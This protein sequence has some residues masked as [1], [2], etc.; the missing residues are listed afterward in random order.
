MSSTPSPAGQT[1]VS[2]PG[3]VLLTGGYLV[4]EAPNPG[5][6]AA[7]S[8][9]FYTTILPCT[10]PSPGGEGYHLVVHSPQFHE[11]R[12]YTVSVSPSSVHVSRLSGGANGYVEMAL[13]HAFAYASSRG[14][15]TPPPP[16]AMADTLVLVADNGF[17][18]QMDALE[19]RGL[20]QSAEGLA[21]LP[22]FLALDTSREL[23]KTGLGSSAALITSLVGA[24][25]VHYAGLDLAGGNTALETV[26]FVA[27]AAH[28]AA[29]GKIGSGF[30]VSSAT[31]GSQRYTRFSPEVLNALAADL[32][33]ASPTEAFDPSPLK[34]HGPEAM[35]S[36]VDPWHLP[37]GM[38]LILA[39]TAVGSKTPGMVR[40]ILKWKADGGDDAAAIWN[41]L[42][43]ANAAVEASLRIVGSHAREF[44]AASAAAIATLASHPLGS[45]ED[46]A[47]GLNDPRA[48]EW[49]AH[50]LRLR[51]EFETVRSLLRAMSTAAGVP[52]EPPEQTALL[53]ATLELPGVVFA[54]VPGAG[55]FD[56]VFV[57]VLGDETRASLESA[58]AQT[59]DIHVCPLILDEDSRG[60]VLIEPSFDLPS[61]TLPASSASKL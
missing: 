57:V 31:F 13:A 43:D 26:H 47:T 15:L 60:G 42:I 14:M 48:S 17:Y 2:A 3:K 1:T 5:L 55:G 44:P 22:P 38:H 28:C 8:A 34:S 50:L 39:D 49:V 54:G 61:H 7:V 45:W 10:S 56:A 52:V 37:Q 32:D 11:T 20:P 4:L 35:D 41:G 40:K 23:V 16:G 46:L 24:V 21:A 59:P 58:W 9:R 25:L 18:S 29:Q 12:E 53:D 30:D 33:L 51:G 27:Q 19:S 36:T 6:V